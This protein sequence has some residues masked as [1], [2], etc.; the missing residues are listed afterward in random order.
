MSDSEKPKSSWWEIITNC[1]VSIDRK[2]K[3]TERRFDQCAILSI[4]GYA[5]RLTVLVAVIFYIKGCP[6]RKMQSANLRM[7]VKHLESQLENQLKS[8]HYQAWQVINAAQG[9]PGGGG[10]KDALEDLHKDGISLIGVDIS[11]AYLPHLELENVNLSNANLS[12]ANLFYA[13]LTNAVLQD[14]NLFDTNLDGADLRHAK[15]YRA[16]L[17][18]ANLCNTKLMEANLFNADVSEAKLISAD[19]SGADLSGANLILANLSRANLTEV[20]FSRAD[21]SGV[22]LWKSDLRSIKNWRDIKSIEKANINDVNNP[23][24]EFIKWAKDNGAVQIEDYGE[25]KK[26][27]REIRQKQMKGK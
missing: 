19:L 25:W 22:D 2:C 5:G 12:K 14:A 13:T 6:E 16:K 8:Q 23:P 15:L 10:R 20:D 11:Q 4:L 18:K 3:P 21:L 9:K 24:D 1:C 7:Q 17:I 26:S 27:L